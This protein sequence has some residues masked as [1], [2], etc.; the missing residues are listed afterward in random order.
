VV[1]AVQ[2]STESADQTGR[3]C[4]GARSCAAAGAPSRAAPW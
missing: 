1:S 4:G 2:G 3:R